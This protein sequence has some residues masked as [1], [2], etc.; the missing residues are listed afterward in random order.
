ME[1]TLDLKISRPN[2]SR[3]AILKSFGLFKTQNVEFWSFR[4]WFFA[5]LQQSLIEALPK[6]LF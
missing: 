1:T 3:L 6:M 2:V 4:E 5:G